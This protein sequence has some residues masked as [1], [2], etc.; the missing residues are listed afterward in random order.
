MSFY[1][2]TAIRAL[3]P[4]RNICDQGQSGL[5]TAKSCI[6]AMPSGSLKT[7]LGAKMEALGQA[8][9]G[10]FNELNTGTLK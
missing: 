5:V 6:T 7:I 3:I 9:Q 2:F 8:L 1:V 4:I 10:K